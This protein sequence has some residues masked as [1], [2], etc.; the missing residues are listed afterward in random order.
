MTSSM[1]VIGVVVMG[2]SDGCC[3]DGSDG[4]CSDGSDGC[5]CS[6]WW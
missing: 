5:C 1:A 2:G 3:S 4:C 6:D